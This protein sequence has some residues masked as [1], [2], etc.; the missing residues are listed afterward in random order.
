[1]GHQLDTAGFVGMSLAVYLDIRFAGSLIHNSVIHVINPK[2]NHHSG[3]HYHEFQFNRQ[4]R[5]PASVATP[6]E[7]APSSLAVWSGSQTLEY[8][9][10][11]SRR[12]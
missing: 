10:R 6:D 12:N 5:Q 9:V 4:A 11:E 1:M 8:R 3:Q 2:S 7:L